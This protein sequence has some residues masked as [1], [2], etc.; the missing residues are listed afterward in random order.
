M[1]EADSDASRTPAV[2]AR[3]RRNFDDLSAQVQPADKSMGVRRGGGALAEQVGGALD[4]EAHMVLRQMA[5]TE[6]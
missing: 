4:T 2:A 1:G 3:S 5:L 6:R